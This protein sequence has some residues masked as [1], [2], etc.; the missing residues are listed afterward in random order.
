MRPTASPEASDVVELLDMAAQ[1]VEF[2]GD[3]A[4]LHQ[5]RDFLLEPLGVDL[6]DK[7]RDALLQ[8]RAD[9]RL[10]LRQA[11]CDLVEDA[12]QLRGARGEH[13]GDPLALARARGREGGERLGEQVRRRGG[14]RRG[15]A[16]GFLDDAGPAQEI[17]GV[18]AAL[19]AEPAPH[20]GRVLDQ[21]V[22]EVLIQR[23]LAA[24]RRSRAD[25]KR[26]VHLAAAR[27]GA[28]G[29]AVVSF[30]GPQFLGQAH[31][32][33][34]IA[35]IDA[36]DLPGEEAR[37]GRALGARETGHAPQHRMGIPAVLKMAADV[38][39]SAV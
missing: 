23:E 32:D 19:G 1:A 39:F 36:A 13:L 38:S 16:F 30:G 12:E 37:G 33:L 24:G 27:N 15:V 9:A 5:D 31:A 7:G 21:P 18:D 6:D 4:L 35:V 25:I 28:D 3:I 20:G 10:D 8:L 29:A 26:R 34:E 14:E 17:H 22:E 11:G 2:L